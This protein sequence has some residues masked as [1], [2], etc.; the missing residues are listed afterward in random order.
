MNNA[1]SLSFNGLYVYLEI[2]WHTNSSF[3][4]IPMNVVTQLQSASQLSE[5]V[6]LLCS[7][8]W[9]KVKLHSH[10]YNEAQFILLVN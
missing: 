1:E 3:I 9:C 8:F 5:I 4:H 6:P 10:Y 2:I 7:F